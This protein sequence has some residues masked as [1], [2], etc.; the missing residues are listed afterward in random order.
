MFERLF[1]GN[2]VTISGMDTLT[3][4]MTC[5]IKTL[6][7]ESVLAAAEA[8][9]EINP[10]NA[11]SLQTLHEIAPDVEIGPAHLTL[12]TRKYWG[13]AGV[14]L[15]VGF[16]ESTRPEVRK[17]ILSHMNAW[18]RYADVSFVETTTDPQVRIAMA[19]GRDGGFWSY[20]GTDIRQVPRD[21]PTM[22]LEGFTAGTPEAMFTRI[23]RHETGHTL[24]FPHEHLRKEIVE[25]IDREAAIAYFRRRHG[26]SPQQTIHNV[27]TP[28]A[29]SAI[30]AD[31]APDRDSIMCYE[32]DASIMRDGVRVEGGADISPADARFIA[33]LYPKG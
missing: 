5:T 3:E 9:I 18:N 12:L 23:V 26:W 20:L 15:T 31:A 6:P 10:A 33:T 30:T 22:N 29:T 21:Q 32:L 17:R 14:R 16:L 27:L 8:A 7:P 25:R 2:R 24:G 19:G 28:L 13:R 1:S 4:T 11:L